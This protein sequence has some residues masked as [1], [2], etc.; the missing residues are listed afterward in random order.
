MYYTLVMELPRIARLKSCAQKAGRSDIIAKL[1]NMTIDGIFESGKI[2]GDDVS[3]TSNGSK[4]DNR[5]FKRC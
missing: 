4:Q 5:V 1:D 2:P 3:E